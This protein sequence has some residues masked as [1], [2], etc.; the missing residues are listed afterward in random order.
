MVSKYT[1]LIIALIGLTIVTSAQTVAGQTGK[2][3]RG[4]DPIWGVDKRQ[5]FIGSLIHTVFWGKI[6][7]ERMP[8]SREKSMWIGG[9]VTISLGIGKEIRDARQPGN[10]F[11]WKDLCADVLGVA[12]GLVL[13]NQ[14]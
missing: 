14:P 11:C 12:V 5:H 13:L 10:H 9:G 7:Q 3:L 2:A 6:V 4:N 8:G 1:F